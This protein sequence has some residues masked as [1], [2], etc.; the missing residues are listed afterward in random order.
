MN[1]PVVSGALSSAESRLR[2]SAP[3]SWGS[4]CPPENQ[5]GKP[6]E[7]A[8]S[9]LVS[10][11]SFSQSGSSEAALRRDPQNWQISVP[12][13][14]FLEHIGQRIASAIL[15]PTIRAIGAQE[16]TQAGG[17]AAQRDTDQD[18]APASNRQTGYQVHQRTDNRYLAQRGEQTAPQEEE[19]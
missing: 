11:K 6:P 4:F 14:L 18:A 12:A 3:A 8:G 5:S 2:K 17:Q 16:N 15:L 10:R 1:P 13:G 19:E 9:E 7:S